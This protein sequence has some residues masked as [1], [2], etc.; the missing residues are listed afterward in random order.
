LYN[1]FKKKAAKK[2]KEESYLDKLTLDPNL[3][4]EAS[5]AFSRLSKDN[6]E[7]SESGKNLKAE[8]L[9]KV[10]D[11]TLVASSILQSRNSKSFTLN[12][13]TNPMIGYAP[14]GSILRRLF[15]SDF[16]RQGFL[17]EAYWACRKSRNEVIVETSRDGYSLVANTSVPKKTIKLIYQVLE[18]L[19]APRQR[20]LMKDTLLWCGNIVMNNKENKDGGLLELNPLLMTQVEPKFESSTDTIISWQVKYGNKTVSIPYN[21][22]DHIKTWNARSHALGM[23]CIASLEVDIEAALQA[24]IYNN[25]VMAKGGLLSVVFALKSPP[26]AD[27]IN[28]KTSMSLCDELTKW[29]QGRFSG[30]RNSGQMAFLPM[31]DKVHVLNKIGEM[32][33]AWGN[34]DKAVGTKVSLQFGLSPERIGLPVTSQYQNLQLVT[35]SISL[36]FDNNNYYYQSIIDDYLTNLIIRDKMGIDGVRIESAGE[37]SSISKTA[38]EVGDLI[39]SLG[40]DVMTVDTFLTEIMHVKG[41]GGELGA[42]FLGEFA[43]IP[44]EGPTPLANKVLGKV[45]NLFPDYQAY[46]AEIIRHRSRDIYYY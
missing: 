5:A 17:A 20:V 1:P 44:K 38:A 25:N 11:T 28:D 29:L 21:P 37:F 7:P 27:F 26:N 31:I 42:K 33:A 39:A 12:G 24:A 6:Y 46:N 36:S 13:N 22:A 23:S 16:M 3:R 10:R 18:D 32:D 45:K 9:L 30:T 43:R 35:D 34:L 8:D 15:P 19:G 4:L 40:V 41:L 2:S 14:G